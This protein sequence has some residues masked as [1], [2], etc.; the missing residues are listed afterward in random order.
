MPGHVNLLEIEVGHGF[1]AGQHIALSVDGANVAGDF[2]TINIAADGTHSYEFEYSVTRPQEEG[3]SS[4]V[5]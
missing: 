3:G 4:D 1:V 2:G 5:R